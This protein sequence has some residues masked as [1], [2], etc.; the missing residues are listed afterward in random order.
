MVLSN[1][2]TCS[3]LLD[4]IP[5]QTNSLWV[6]SVP[7]RPCAPADGSEDFVVVGTN[8]RALWPALADALLMFPYTR[9]ARL[10]LLNLLCSQQ[11][12]EYC[13]HLHAAVFS[14]THMS[15]SV[16]HMYCN[17]LK[18]GSQALVLMVVLHHTAACCCCL[19]AVLSQF[20]MSLP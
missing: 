13:C 10:A 5:V 1:G 2:A 14:I 7:S 12:R 15:L 4:C 11:V 16:M 20:D 17:R 8:T 3:E 6:F 19:I 9:D 18:L